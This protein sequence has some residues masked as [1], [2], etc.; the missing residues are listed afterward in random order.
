MSE[1]PAELGQICVQVHPARAPGL[2]TTALKAAAELL[3]RS[4]EDVRG[5]EFSE[6]EDDGAYLNILFA[7]LN[8]QRSWPTIQVGLLESPIF[9]PQLKASAMA[10]CTGAD[11]WNDYLLLYH[12]DPSVAHSGEA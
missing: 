11:G 8:P 5:I 10:V 7:S 2:S 1:E 6:G 3:A 9:G 4:A 12:Y